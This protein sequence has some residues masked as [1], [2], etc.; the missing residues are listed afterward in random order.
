MIWCNVRI[1][2]AVATSAA[3]G[4]PIAFAGTIS[5]IYV[6]W[7]E[8]GLPPH[9]LGFVYVPALLLIVLAS[10]TLAP[11]GARMAHGMPVRR[12]QRIFVGILYALAAY[13]LWKGLA[14]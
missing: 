9:S 6:G 13:M 11:V 2:N 12:L 14:A 10:M 5:N 4:F 7:G 1:Q 3:L 8:P